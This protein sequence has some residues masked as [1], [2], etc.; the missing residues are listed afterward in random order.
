LAAHFLLKG[1]P[2]NVSWS[3][4]DMV[5]RRSPLLAG[6]PRSWMLWGVNPRFKWVLEAL[7]GSTVFLYVTRGPGV[8]GGLALY[9]TAREVVD[10][11]EPYWPEGS[12]PAAFYLEVRAAVP[13][14]LERPGDPASWR[15]VARERLREV[16]VPVLPGPQRLGE[17][18]AE[19]LKRLIEERCRAQVR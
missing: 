12:W 7:P 3:L 17:R 13:G 19:A 9:G 15:L 2:R 1:S 5:R 6:K 4:V 8:E 14:A 18:E 10:L 11:S 16:G